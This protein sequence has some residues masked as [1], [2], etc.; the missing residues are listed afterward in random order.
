MTSCS[1]SMKKTCL[2]S[3]LIRSILREKISSVKSN[4]LTE[5]QDMFCFN[6]ASAFY[7]N[8]SI[9]KKLMNNEFKADT[10]TENPT[11]NSCC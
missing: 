11:G 6:H 1:P 7:T 3:L 10:S 2:V 5:Q 9:M 4:E 8:N